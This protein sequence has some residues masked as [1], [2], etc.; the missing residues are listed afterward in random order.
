[1]SITNELLNTVLRE[2]SREVSRK[3]FLTLAGRG[4]AVGV[5]AG[6]LASCQSEGPAD[7]KAATT[8]TTGTP[9]SEVNATTTY[10]S[11]GG[12][13]VPSSEAVSPP[14]KV[15]TA[16]DQPIE[17]EKWKSD[18]DPQSGP[19][20]TPLPPDKRVGYALVGLGHLTLEEILPAFGECKKSKP[21]AL[22]SASPEK[23]KKVAQ[24]YGIKPENCYSYETY[25]KLKDNPEVQVIYIVL[26][27]SMHAE[28]TIRGAQAGKH[29]LCEKPMA[30]SSAECQAMIDACKKANK[31][32]MVAYRIQYEPYNR[33]VKE[34][35]R[36]NKFGKPKYIEAQNSQSSANPDHWRHK[37]ALA[38]GGALPDIGL[39]CL[40]TSRF[41][42][43]TEPTEVFAYSYSTP[44]NPLFKEVEEVMSWQMR[45]PEGILVNCITHYNTHDSRFYRV[46]TE[47][48]WIHVD[49]AYAYTGQQ[50]QTSHAEGPAK[51]K[52]QIVLS[53][54]NQFAAEMD[55]FSEC[56]MEDKAPHTPGEE[57]LQDHRIMEA[58]YQS[59]REGRPVKLTEVKGTDVFRGPEPKQA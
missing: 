28:Y 55:H 59:A 38:G 5:A 4:L 24:Q 21:V 8:P 10:T 23:L 51:M 39:Y 52:N 45:F 43:G 19:V 25:D 11:P 50:L 54:K 42:L 14:A 34:M 6:T 22:V 36:G 17:L 26:P 29:I 7:A 56:V 27:N 41:V 47:R 20:P 3:E 48:G 15:P 46:N 16:L 40:N 30:N 12:Q 2:A 13:K 32:L 49:N 57:G 44:G 58:I 1:M 9:A 31:K 33:Q 37:K 53:E 18:V 35:V